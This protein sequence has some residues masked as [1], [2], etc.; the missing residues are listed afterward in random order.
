MNTGAEILENA[1]Y[2]RDLVA[3]YKQ[4]QN[5]DLDYLAMLEARLAFAEIEETRYM[6]MLRKYNNHHCVN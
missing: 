2:Y 3:E 5:C 4:V 6:R 1:R